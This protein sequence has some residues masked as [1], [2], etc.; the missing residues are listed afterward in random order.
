MAEPFAGMSEKSKA[1]GVADA[2]NRLIQNLVLKCAKADGVRDYFQVGII[3]YGSKVESY[4]GGSLPDD[5]LVPVSHLADHP[6]RIETRTRLSDDG[7]GGVLEQQIKFPIWFD[8]HAQGKTAMN[9]AF[10]AAEMVVSGFILAH[11]E[12][13]PPIILHLSDGKPTDANPR[14]CVR[15]IQNLATS[16]GPV[17]IF[18]LLLSTEP[19]A[20]MYFLNDEELLLDKYAKLLFRMSSEL[21]PR[22]L[23][24]AKADGFS[25]QPGARGVVFNADLVAVVR[26]LDIGTR[27]TTAMR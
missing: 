11:P 24:A 8:A 7:A 19:K 6:I 26:F 13:Y 21:P 10:E 3:G 2:V 18:N 25:V 27:I 14:E 5:C 4:L 1:D 22:L 9:A 16:D 12:S 20:P 15:R 17:L 23:S